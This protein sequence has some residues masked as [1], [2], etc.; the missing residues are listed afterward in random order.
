MPFRFFIGLHDI[1]HIFHHIVIECRMKW[2]YLE[3]SLPLRAFYN[4]TIQGHFHIT[5]CDDL[6][7]GGGKQRQIQRMFKNIHDALHLRWFF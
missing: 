6:N 1:L 2:S 4:I 7:G 3:N 5:I